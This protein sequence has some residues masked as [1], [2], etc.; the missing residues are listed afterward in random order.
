MATGSAASA[1]TALVIK[2]IDNVLKNK[3]ITIQ[4][5]ATIVDDNPQMVQNIWNWL[6]D[7]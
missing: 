3:Y 5:I 2:V 7:N 4:D 1:T 6:I